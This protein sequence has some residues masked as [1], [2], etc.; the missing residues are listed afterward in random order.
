M[1]CSSSKTH[2]VN[3]YQQKPGHAQNY[4]LL[5]TIQNRSLSFS[6]S[7]RWRIIRLLLGSYPQ[8]W[9]S[10]SPP[11]LGGGSACGVD[12]LADVRFRTAEPLVG[13]GWRVW[14]RE[15]GSPSCDGVMFLRPRGHNNVFLIV[16][17]GAFGHIPSFRR[18]RFLRPAQK[19]HF[20]R[21]RSRTTFLP[22]WPAA[23]P[24]CKINP[25]LRASFK[26][27][28]F[29]VTANMAELLW[30]LGTFSRSKWALGEDCFDSF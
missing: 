27:R 29:P 12:F 4:P 18:S 19:N 1:Q 22:S 26:Y 2:L 7:S 28:L 11:Q 16:S 15:G 10:P 6:A 8:G 3:L 21:L 5:L 9:H 30:G 20:S 23:R 13:V 14:E 17:E 25:F 24:K